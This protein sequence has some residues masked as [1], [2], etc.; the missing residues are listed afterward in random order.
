MIYLLDTHLLI[1][2]AGPTELLSEAA[3]DVIEDRRNVLMFSALS[4]HEVAIKAGRERTDFRVDPR[5]FRD[6]LL[7]NEL[8]EMPFTSEHALA[9]QSLPDIHRDPFDRGLVAQAI[10]EQITLLTADKRV[11]AY[12][13]PI[14]RV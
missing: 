8:E 7:A 5:S 6:N 3:R 2:L 14:M 11:A 9:V 1:W 10:S 13:G 4:I 12:P